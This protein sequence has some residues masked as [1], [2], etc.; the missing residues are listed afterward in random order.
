[1]N[2]TTFIKGLEDMLQISELP[3]EAKEE[4]VTTLSHNIL[5]RTN[6]VI[7]STLNEEE[8]KVLNEL[9][10]TGKIEEAMNLLGETHPELDDMVVAISKE[11]V[12][13]FLGEG[14]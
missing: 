2:Y 7:A 13:E 1:M 14:K 4:I 8:A 12:D 5:S 11:V 3:D 6:I 10:E 9:L